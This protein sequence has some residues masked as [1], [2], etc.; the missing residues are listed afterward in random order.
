VRTLVVGG[1]GFIGA[2]L[3][4]RLAAA[5]HTVTVV[6]NLLPQVHGP[7]A[8]FPEEL[9]S[10]ARCIRSDVRRPGALRD[11]LRGHDLVYWLAA[12][13]GTGQSMYRV[14]RYAD[15]N[16]GALATF[17]DLLVQNRGAVS[18]VVL[19]SSRAVY[20]EG[21]YHCSSHGR[22]VPSGRLG[23]DPTLGWNPP[24]P[25]CGGPI[26]ALPTPEESPPRPGSVYGWTKL[27][28]EQ[29]LELLARATGLET[30]VLRLQNVYGAGQALRNPYTGVLM[31]FCNQALRGEPLLLYEDGEITRDFVHVDDVVAALMTAGTLPSASGGVFNIGSGSPVT[32]RQ[33]A[34]SVV[35]LSG[36][37][38]PLSVG[39]Q[40]RVGDVRYAVGHIG[41]A[42]QGLS[43]RPRM[44]FE[45]GIQRVLAWIKDQGTV[46]D[47]SAAS[48]RELAARGLLRSAQR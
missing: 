13:T 10:V 48:A 43:Y 33:A 15:A 27:A 37:G 19:T 41:R 24:C 23:H 6:D 46:P 16:V 17:Y 28:Q 22:V 9:T 18:R 39:G 20:G 5:G 40:F 34:E 31:V 12:E 7:A 3:T 25:V 4:P 32:I 42:A 2:H 21:A 8:E 44:A 35:A 26:A 11:L 29:L 36:H 1:A 14:R 30:V 47:R 38:S 45:E